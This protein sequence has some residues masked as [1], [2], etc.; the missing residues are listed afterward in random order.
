MRYTV[1]LLVMWPLICCQQCDQTWACITL[2]ISIAFLLYLALS[3]THEL[4]LLAEFGPS[5][6]W[7]H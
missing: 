4:R 2:S 7:P 3:I 6:Q 1:L 5:A